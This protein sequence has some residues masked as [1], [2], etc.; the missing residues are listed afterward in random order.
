LVGFRKKGV[1]VRVGR[2][3]RRPAQKE[4]RP[5]LFFYTARRGIARVK[6]E[7]FKE[8]APRFLAGMLTP[9]TPAAVRKHIERLVTSTSPQVAVRSMR[10]M[11]D[12]KLG[13]DDPVR[14]P[15]Q[16]LMARSPFWTAE[17]K[18]FVKKLVPDLDY[19][20]FEGVGHFLFM[21]KP[22]EVNE[23]LTEFLK[24]QGIVK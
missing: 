17:Y 24:K 3:E 14:V 12:R 21:E 16:A 4:R 6:G 11:L 15:A 10:G 20:E 13:K 7:T 5:S 19:R 8:T 1:V 23:A 22:K 18:E 9:A 2:T